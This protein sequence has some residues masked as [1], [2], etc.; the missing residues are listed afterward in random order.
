MKHP[1]NL[2][3]LTSYTPLWIVYPYYIRIISYRLYMP[4]FTCL[5]FIYPCKL[6]I[7][8]IPIPLQVTY[9]YRLYILMNHILQVTT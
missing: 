7:L 1:Y 8:K 6:Y 4:N 2:Y 5:E 3:T 9:P